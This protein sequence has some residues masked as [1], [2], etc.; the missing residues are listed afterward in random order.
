MGDMEPL[1]S[2][3]NDMERQQKPIPFKPLTENLNCQVFDAWNKLNEFSSEAWFIS[4]KDP[5]EPLMG[6]TRPLNM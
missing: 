1:V 2:D 3:K 5:F 4:V 6:G